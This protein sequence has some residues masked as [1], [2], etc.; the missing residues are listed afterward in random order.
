MQFTRGVNGSANIVIVLR[1]IYTQQKNYSVQWICLDKTHKK[2]T[3]L[4]TFKSAVNIPQLLTKTKYMY[5][6]IY[7]MS[8]IHLLLIGNV[9]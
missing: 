4:M 9:L 7:V 5:A 6:H 8:K 1:P 3:G 2:L